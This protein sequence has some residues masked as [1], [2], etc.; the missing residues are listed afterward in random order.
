MGRLICSNEHGYGA[1]G[2]AGIYEIAN[3]T[4]G[5][6]S[7]IQQSLQPTAVWPVGVATNT[8]PVATNSRRPGDNDS[9][10]GGLAPGAIAGIVIGII[11]VLALIAFL[12]WFIRRRK[13]R[14]A[15]DYRG[16]EHNNLDL[17]DGASDRGAGGYDDPLPADHGTVSPY[18][19]QNHTALPGESHSMTATPH[20]SD[21]GNRSENSASGFAGLGA[22]SAFGAAAGG[23]G[24]RSRQGSGAG[25]GHEPARDSWT[26]SH[27]DSMGGMGGMN[28]GYA[29]EDGDARAG[30]GIAPPLPPKGTPFRPSSSQPSTIT[31]RPDSGYTQFTHHSNSMGHASKRDSSQTL[32]SRLGF[33]AGFGQ[34]G[35]GAAPQ[36]PPG[37]GAVG[38]GMPGV[39]GPNRGGM[40]I[41]NHDHPDDLPAVDPTAGG[42]SGNGT[43]GASGHGRRGQRNSDDFNNRRMEFRRH[44][45]AG[46]VDYVDLPPLYTDVPRDGGDA[47]VMRGPAQMEDMRGSSYGSG[48]SASPLPSADLRGVGGMSG[49]ESPTSPHT[50]LLADVDPLS[51]N[52]PAGRGSGN[53]Q[54]RSPLSR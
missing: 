50:P 47:A 10:G 54:R 52:D 19:S 11:A 18:I 49:N 27:G 43:A 6:S 44:A 39:P 4:G 15:D 36:L 51:V 2:A 53:G 31:G 37:A 13:R 48:N 29:M 41:V 21:S 38:P 46:R 12:V 23:S 5:S 34:T 7:C 26:Y 20:R 9:T 1:G 14:N 35:S 16:K 8:L 28:M 17:A 22:A 25:M 24:E 42:T 30:P 3:N 45:D 32:Q 40:R 33:G